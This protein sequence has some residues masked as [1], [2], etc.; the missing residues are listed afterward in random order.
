M[1]PLK[2]K[3]CDKILFSDNVE[4]SS[5]IFKKVISD[6]GKADVKQQEIKGL[7]AVTWI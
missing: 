7:V 5:K 4:W 6:D 3:V 1:N 2:K